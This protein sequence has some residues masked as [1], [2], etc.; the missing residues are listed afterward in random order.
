MDDER[1]ETELCFILNG[2]YMNE[3]EGGLFEGQ[4]E[5]SGVG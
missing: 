3:A 1:R 5:T 2:K 4:E